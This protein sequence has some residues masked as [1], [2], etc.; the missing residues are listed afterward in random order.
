[1]AFTCLRINLEI[2][3]GL[4][5]VY[6]LERKSKK[7]DEIIVNLKQASYTRSL[8]RRVF[9]TF[10]MLRLEDEQ[11]SIRY[12]RQKQQTLEVVERVQNLTKAA[13]LRAEEVQLSQ[14]NQLM[15]VVSFV[16]NNRRRGTPVG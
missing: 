1:L 8:L 5:E 7:M 15:K 16:K 4:R 6:A 9:D 11:Q 14:E 12:R 13:E 10:V 3:I 2:E